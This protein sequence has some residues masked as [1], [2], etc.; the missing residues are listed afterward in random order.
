MTLSRRIILLFPLLVGCACAFAQTQPI[1]RDLGRLRANI[2]ANVGVYTKDPV[3]SADQSQR[4]GTNTFLSLGYDI[5]KFRFGAQYDIFEPPMI[6]Y[7]EE[8]KGNKIMQAFASFHSD[9]FEA[10]LGSF[11]EQ[12]GSG[13]L[14]RS[15]E[16]RALGINTVMLGASVRVRPWDWITVKAMAGLPRKFMTYANARVY[17]ADGDLYLDKLLNADSDWSIVAGGGWLL[18]DD[19]S[20]L[21][22]EKKAP[23]AVR[24]YTSRLRMA[25]GA[26]ALGAEYTMKSRNYM[27]S[28]PSA[29]GQALLLNGSLDFSGFGVSAEFRTI[30]NMEFAMDDIY[31]DGETPALN[32]IPS[33]TKLHKYALL[34]LYPHRVY[35]GEI[36]GQ[37]EVFGSIPTGRYPLSFSMN[38]SMYKGLVPDAGTPGQYKPFDLSGKLLFAE[39]GI[40]VEK[41]WNRSW[42]TTLVADWQRKQEFSTLGYGMMTMNTATVVLDALYKISPKNS[43]RAEL[44]HAWSDSKD[45]QGWVMG[46]LE[47]GLAP[48]WM[49]YVSDMYN[50]KTAGKSI[51]YYSVG[52]SYTWRMLRIAG[53]YGRYRAGYQCSGGVCRYIPE[54]TGFTLSLSVNI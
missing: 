14:F 24:G 21:A 45:H 34:S 36:G 42:K 50:Y 17:G 13:L 1:K 5:G 38:A 26:L 15:F 44:Q 6:G 35:E 30:Q 27:R 40:E 48:S 41:K 51:H 8:F 32:Y 9:R 19:H 33:L 52:G 47:W 3:L 18:R 12:F 46:L 37:V 4:F 10:T 53:A 20:K 16:D 43:L 31:G 29:E 39:T 7:P 28:I 23:Q 2:D 54:H 49:F 25:K 22:E 11:Y